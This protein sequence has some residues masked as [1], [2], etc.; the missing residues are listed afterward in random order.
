METTRKRA[1]GALLVGLL[2]SAAVALAPTVEAKG[3]PLCHPKKVLPTCPTGTSTTSTTSTTVASSTTSSST[4]TSTSTTTTSTTSTSTTSTTVPPGGGSTL[5]L[6]DADLDADLGDQTRC[7]DK[8]ARNGGELT[9]GLDPLGIHGRVYRAHAISDDDRAEWRHAFL[10]CDGDTRLNLWGVDGPGTT[11]VYVGWRSQFTGNY[12]INT[13][14]DNG[15]N[16]VQWKGDSS[17]GGP[18]VGMTIRYGRLS[19]RTIDG[20][21]P[22]VEGLWTDTVPFSTRLNDWTDFVMRVGFSKGSDGFIELWVDGVQQTMSDGTTRHEGPTVCADD[23][24]V[25]TKF[26]VYSVPAGADA[27]HWLEDPRI[28]TSY[29]A[30]AP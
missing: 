17:C 25:T 11:D 24:R 29:A 1:A 26:G 2:L 16:V 15:G 10:D 12:A 5:W 13:G 28:G 21:P 22:G 4:T 27:Y 19:L 23:V 14:S 30:V 9:I 7:M 20:D 6:A 3:K 18:A 8:D